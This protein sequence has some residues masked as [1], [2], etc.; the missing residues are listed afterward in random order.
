L[1]NN[2][3]ENDPHIVVNKFNSFFTEIGP[4]LANS[5]D[6]PNG[7]SFEDYLRNH[8]D[9]SF[10]FTSVTEKDVTEAI[11]DLKP[12]SSCGSD[13]LSNKLVKLMK[14]IIVKPLTIII[15]QSLHNGIFPQKMKIA[16]V[17]P[18]HKKNE[19]YLFDNYRPV[20]LLPSLSKLLEKIMHKQL[21]HYFDESKLLYDS[22]YGFR[23]RHSTELAALEIVDTLVKQMDDNEIPINIY[24]DLSKAFDTLD[25]KILISKLQF[26]GVGGN[27]LKLLKDYLTNRQQYVVFNNHESEFRKIITGVPQGS[28]LG[29]LLFIIYLNDITMATD[30]FK[31][32]IYADDTALSATLNSFGTITQNL[33][34]NINSEL[35]K[36]N[37]WL[38]VNKLSL[39]TNKTKVMLFH[40]PQ[41]KIRDINLKLDNCGIEVVKKFNYLG[42]IL[43]SH[44]SW[45]DHTSMIS[46][47]IAR[48]NGIMCRLKNIIPPSALLLIYNSLV[49]PYLSYGLLVWGH[50]SKK[51]LTLQ[52]RSVRT[53]VNAKYNS[54]T[55][56][57]FKNLNLLKVTELY[58]V[59]ELKFAYKLLNKKLP[60][61]FLNKQYLRHA[62]IHN[63]NTRMANN[64]QCL[65]ARHT[66]VNNS[67]CYR[68]PDIL[69]N[70]PISIKQKINTHSLNGFAN[71]TKGYYI[72]K[73]E[74]ECH[75]DNCYICNIHNN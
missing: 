38:K 45:N 64:L 50:K 57:I 42:I 61:Y 30:M 26:Y 60:I 48:T 28:I 11:N 43:D 51:L 10:V 56:P 9:K 67:I 24:L 75:I 37:V 68:I 71:Y 52:K 2:L 32:I 31:P 34:M 15:N 59:Q 63:Y 54:H 39:N 69:N 58:A 47:K 53:I 23:N 36:V 62:D 16:K 21:F 72:G 55:E 4:T 70:C 12:K 44:L 7:K 18:L 20:S 3:P 73:Y 65:P 35:E 13:N 19:N 27:S 5:I 22:Q 40:T 25:H 74:V 14:D 29:P 8:T 41:R 66:F 46:H 33:E 49:L 17:L 6:M 1:I